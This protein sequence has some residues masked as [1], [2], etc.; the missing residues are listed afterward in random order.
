MKPFQLQNRLTGETAKLEAQTFYEAC[1][2]LGWE[3]KYVKLLN[4]K[5]LEALKKSKMTDEELKVTKI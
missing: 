2:K 4:Y 3:V 1:E 5:E